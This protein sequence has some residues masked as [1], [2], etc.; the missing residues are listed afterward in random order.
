MRC[1]SCS[2]NW[3]VR[4]LGWSR[5]TAHGSARDKRKVGHPIA[6][7]AHRTVEQVAAR[8]AQG[9]ER[10]QHTRRGLARP[11]RLRI[12]RPEGLRI[13]YKRDDSVGVRVRKQ[14][15]VRL[16]QSLRLRNR[17]AQFRRG[18][19]GDEPCRSLTV[20]VGAQPIRQ[21]MRDAAQ[22]RLDARRAAVEAQQPRLFDKP[23]PPVDLPS[24]S[25]PSRNAWT[26]LRSASQ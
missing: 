10:L 4:G 19:R 8:G 14:R 20:E 25:M 11:R 9:A 13:V 18:K 22:L 24:G 21:F 7:C 5:C 17:D 3:S 1:S 26:V 15:R 2:A 6:A 23:R 16:G 12:Q